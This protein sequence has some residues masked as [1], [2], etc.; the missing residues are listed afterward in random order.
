[1]PC[2][3]RTPSPFPSSPDCKRLVAGYVGMAMVSDR[4]LVLRCELPEPF[5]LTHLAFGGDGVGANSPRYGKEVIDDVIVECASVIDLENLDRNAGVLILVAEVS[6]LVH[7]QR[8]TPFAQFLCRSLLLR[9]ERSPATSTA[10]DTSGRVV[11]GRVNA[12][13][14][15]CAST[16]CKR[17]SAA[18]RFS[19]VMY[20]R[21][22]SA[23][24]D[25]RVKL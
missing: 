13:A 23:A 7:R 24:P 1:M 14:L 20:S 15:R 16:D 11:R 8:Q 19:C 5:G 25:M 10:A 18:P 9:S 21:I 22:L 6:D 2:T 4:H 12:G 17:R 3:A